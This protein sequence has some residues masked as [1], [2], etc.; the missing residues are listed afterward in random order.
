MFS[1]KGLNSL[2][3]VSK[4]LDGQMFVGDH[5]INGISF[6]SRNAAITLA[7]A[8]ESSQLDGYF[9]FES[10]SSVCPDI[11]MLFCNCP[12]IGIILSKAL[13]A[14]SFEIFLILQQEVNY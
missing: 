12:I 1:V 4:F 2:K 6:D 3:D 8:T 9:W 11:S 13:I 5:E 7:R 14:F 10:D